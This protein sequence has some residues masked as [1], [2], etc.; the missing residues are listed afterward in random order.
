MTE[1][2]ISVISQVKGLRVIS[3]T[4]VSQYKGATKPIAQIGVELGA[5]SVLEGSVRKSGDRLRITV[6]LIDTKTDEHRWAQT[7]DRK[8][9]DVFAIQADLAE[10]TA[11]ALRVELLKSEREILQERPTSNF[12]AYE[13]YLRGVQVSLRSGSLFSLELDQEAVRH[14]E[15]AIREDPRFA[16]AYAGLANHFVR[17]AGLTRTWTEVAERA[18][19]LSTKA[20]ELDPNSSEAHMAQGNLLMQF[21]RDWD[22]AESEF[23]QAIALNPSNVEVRRWYAGL[24]NI[25]QR[26]D[27]AKKHLQAAVEQDPLNIESRVSLVGEAELVGDYSSETAL[28]EEMVNDFPDEPLPRWTLAWMYAATGR[29]LEA[30]R[31]LGPPPPMSEVSY[32]LGHAAI[33]AWLGKADEGRALLAEWEEGRLAKGLDAN[34]FAFLCGAMGD[35]ERALTLL[36]RSAREGGPGLSLNYQSPVFDSIR[37]DPR[38]VG[39]LE[40]LDLPTTLPRPL[41]RRP[42][43]SS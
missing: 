15:R 19:E 5:D 11:S 12:A 43:S 36:E 14:F 32:R 1:E 27:E 16:S 9:E 8:L 37:G 13:A 7:Y 24:L 3:R 35:T 26:F 18:R 2:L 4:S 21:D 6:Q 17:M 34:L 38:F 22:R 33:M 28:L 39:L 42:T 30:V 23:Q 25:L 10:R 20:L 40:S 29:S 31:M 41:L